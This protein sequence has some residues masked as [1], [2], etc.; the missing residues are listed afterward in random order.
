MKNYKFTISGTQYE[1]DILSI[2]GNIAKIEVNGTPYLVEIQR[3]I[4]HAKTPTIVRSAIKDPHKGIEKK[5]GGAKTVIKSPLP[6]III[7][8]FV[9]AGDEVKKNQKLFS[10]EAMKME[11]EIKAERDGKVASISVSPGQTVLQEEIIM[12]MD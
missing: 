1:V 5:S 12:E 6:G 9:K 7:S 11:N 2:E 3:E 10:L 8:I 4:K